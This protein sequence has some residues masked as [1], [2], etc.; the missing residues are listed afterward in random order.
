MTF[1]DLRKFI[2]NSKI[3]KEPFPDSE[4]GHH[5]NQKIKL[6][7]RRF[8]I[9]RNKPFWI[10]D[11]SEHKRADIA[12]NGA[13]CF[14]HII[15][16]PHKDNREHKIYDYE[17][18]VFNQ[19]EQYKDIFIKKA[20]GLGIT[21][22]LLRYMCWLCVKD[23]TY[24]NTRFH[25]VTGPRINLAEDLIDRIYNM[26]MNKL[27]ISCTRTGPIICVN[28]VTIQAFPSH[29]ISSSRGYTD[30]KFILIDEAAFFIES[31]QEECRAVCEAYRAKS[32]PYI[33]MVST[34]YKVNDMFHTIDKDPNSRFHKINLSYEVG[35]GKIYDPEELEK[36]R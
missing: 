22:L 25:I 10:E 29:T 11:I 24:K 6:N 2:D 1:K 20:R 23:D 8:D 18:E 5:Y 15:G 35:I 9:F 28:D 36:V 26:F 7:S 32:K 27:N 14:N 21:E 34:P 3:T 30:V 4:D 33:V 31:Q 16:L 19:L 13:C 17:L 12:S